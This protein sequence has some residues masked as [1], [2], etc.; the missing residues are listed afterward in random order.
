MIIKFQNNNRIIF[1]YK[2]LMD[3]LKEVS[4]MPKNIPYSDVLTEYYGLKSKEM[5][6]KEK[7]VEKKVIEEE[8]KTVDEASKKESTEEIATS[9]EEK[10]KEEEKKAKKLKEKKVEH[11]VEHVKDNK[12]LSRNKYKGDKVKEKKV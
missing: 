5:N 6:D 7:K 12:E 2:E 4:K 1:T 11:V 9:T 8:K 3:S 10:H